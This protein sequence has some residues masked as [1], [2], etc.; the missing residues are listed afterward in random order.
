MVYLTD[1][2]DYSVLY[3]V[4]L[5][6]QLLHT[7]QLDVPKSRRALLSVQLGAD[8]AGHLWQTD[9]ANTVY[10]HDGSAGKLMANFTAAF[11]PALLLDRV[12]CMMDEV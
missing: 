7:W 6:G 3:V 4:S 12:S 10:K 8:S 1:A 2:A 11:P 9:A 5:D